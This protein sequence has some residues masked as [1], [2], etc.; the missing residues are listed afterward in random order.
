MGRA[1][2]LQARGLA[3]VIVAICAALLALPGSRVARAE[4]TFGAFIE[5]L[6][7]DARDVGVPRAVF[8]RAFAGVTPDLSLPDLLIPGRDAAPKRGQAEFTQPATA[9]LNAASLAN[10][11][12]EGRTL[13]ARHKATLERIEREIGVDR[14]ALLAI[15]GRETAFGAEK[16]PHD[17]IRVLATQAYLGSRKEMFR[18]E[19]IAALRILAL[20]VPRADL[21]SS[22]A[23]AFG[24]TQFMPTEYFKNGVDFD[25]DGRIDLAHS[26][27]DAL[28][29]AARQLKEK[30]WVLGQP[31]GYEVMVPAASSCALEGPPGSRTVAEWLAMGFKRPGN[32]LFRPADLNAQAY[33][34]MPAGAHGPA[35]LALENFQVIRRYNTSDLYALYVGNLA[36]RIAGGG[37]FETPWAPVAQ[38]AT[39]LVADLQTR[40]KA[41]GYPMDKIDGKIGSNTRRQIGI[42]ETDARLTVDC[43]PTPGVLDAAVARKAQ[44]A[45]P[46]P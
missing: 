38:P 32:K 10:L 36:D 20:G 21:K 1:L 6:W 5:G 14:Y 42:F 2:T 15:W 40:L 9:Y 23:G 43:W 3:A 37:N 7:P 11:A 41:L 12:A 44:A 45:A 29:S 13:L 25:G 39:K 28:A 27:A 30:G 46:A 22:W 34:M 8:D 17:A 18:T 24:L 26:V 31:W 19:L 33:L 16:T 35:F 4:G